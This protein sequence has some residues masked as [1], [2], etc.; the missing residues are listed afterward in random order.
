MEAADAFETLA[1]FY[2]VH[3]ITCNYFLRAL[4]PY[5]VKV[6]FSNARE[7]EMCGLRGLFS[8]SVSLLAYR[9]GD[10]IC[11]NS[12]QEASASTNHAVPE[13]SD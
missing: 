1:N 3:D 6:F 11:V 5:W 4:I 8:Q 12:E 10:K 7:I 9:S 2:P 13:I